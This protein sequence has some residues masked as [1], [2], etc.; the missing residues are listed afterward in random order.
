MHSFWL[1]MQAVN[2]ITI[3]LWGVDPID[4]FMRLSMVHYHTSSYRRIAEFFYTPQ[5]NALSK[6][7]YYSNFPY[8]IQFLDPTSHATLSALIRTDAILAL[9]I[10]ENYKISKV[11]WFLHAWIYMRIHQLIP[12]VL[13]AKDCGHYS[14][15]NFCVLVESGNTA[16]RYVC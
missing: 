12:K 8:H 13:I 2:I 11:V 15:V 1:L 7:W 14:T 16:G 5:E 9:F 6:V 10:L 4:V 3:G